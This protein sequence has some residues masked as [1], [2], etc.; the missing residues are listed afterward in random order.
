[1]CSNH[2]KGPEK[3]ISTDFKMVHKNGVLQE[4]P[5][6]PKN[7]Y[8]EASLCQARPSGQA[9][10]CSPPW[11][12]LVRLPK[13]TA[14]GSLQ[15]QPDSLELNC[16]QILSRFY[17]LSRRRSLQRRTLTRWLVQ[18]SDIWQCLLGKRVFEAALML[19][20][21]HT[22]NESWPGMMDASRPSRLKAF[23]A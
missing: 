3:H 18:S 8:E 23:S 17:V 11:Q 20:S 5:G 12:Q 9:A 19:L 2:S 1:M 22:K 7:G 6:I 14:L 15:H 16:L 13:L 10:L 4:E 21:G